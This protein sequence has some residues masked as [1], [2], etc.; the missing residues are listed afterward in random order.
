[1]Y[2]SHCRFS[3]I[4]LLSCF[5]LLSVPT[6][7]SVP[8][9]QSSTSVF[10]S[11]DAGLGSF[12]GFPVSCYISVSPPLLASMVCNSSQSVSKDNVIKHLYVS[13]TQPVAI[14][15]EKHTLSKNNKKSERYLSSY[16]PSPNIAGLHKYPPAYLHLIVS[17]PSP[18]QSEIEIKLSFACFKEENK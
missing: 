14:V 13:M 2:I 10:A 18:K 9:C 8:S 1:M 16:P 6:L 11:S 15:T 17:P 4:L 12:R 7:A 5:F 3:N